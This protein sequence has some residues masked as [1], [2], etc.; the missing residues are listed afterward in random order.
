MSL[1]ISGCASFEPALHHSNLT[2]P[3][4]PTVK[5]TQEGLEVSI[6]EFVSK[7]KSEAAFD[8]DV[9]PH[10]ILALLLRVE[11]GGTQAYWVRED[12]VSAYMGADSLPAVSG[13]GAAKQGADRGYLGRALLWTLAS[14][15]LTFVPIVVGSV[16]H[17]S[18]VNRRIETH[19][20]SLSFTE[21]LL[22]PN[23][24]AAGFLYF[25]LP[26]GIERL[27]NLRVEVTSTEEQTGIPL[28]YKFTLPTLNLR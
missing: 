14:G 20:E 22:K 3:R 18:A 15:P 9:A 10:G 13:R 7:D 19:F 8:A 5:E 16:A 21:G 25:K 28:S 27:E 6:E 11:N 12:G 4:E 17:T 1:V 2:K 23:Q 26:S 24:I